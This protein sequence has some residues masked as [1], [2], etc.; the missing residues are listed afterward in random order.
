MTSLRLAVFTHSL[1]SDWNNGNAHFLR[2]LMRA[3][4]AMGHEV[5]CFEP[6][7]AWSIQ[8]LLATERTAGEK[9]IRRFQEVYADLDVRKYRQD[10]NLEDFLQAELK[11]MDIML[12]HEWNEPSLV[13]AILSIRDRYKKLALF[14]DTHHRASSTPESLQKLQVHRFDGVLAFGE[15]LRK[16]Y[17]KRWSLVRVWTL[18][19][20]ADTS[21]FRPFPA[22]K[23]RDVVWVGNWG[24]EER[25]KELMEYLIYPASKLQKLRFDV[26][27]VRY[28]EEG[29]QA[30]SAADIVYQGYL[31]N[32][33]APCVYAES[34]I[35]LHVPRREYSSVLEGIPT[36]RVF[37][38]LACG[39]PLISAPWSDVEE[40][41][42][43]EDYRLV[44]SGEEMV[45]TIRELLADE[46]AR[47]QQAL[48]GLET[49]MQRHS[50]AHRAEQ[51]TAICEELLQ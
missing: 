51:L 30:L 49:I 39:V 20:A 16:I 31:P 25:T 19:E 43:P 29:K 13:D 10:E 8:N 34:R 44:R 17:R 6:E 11:D 28:P 48:S 3:M 12:V 41:F 26:Y 45:W 24:D 9:E 38:A 4:V 50:C 40:L 35:T 2:G 42:R 22:E 27:G 14:H 21:I 47:R 5:R 33:S 15:S 36:I 46:A 32:L 1:R 18:H 7:Q 37:E 23:K